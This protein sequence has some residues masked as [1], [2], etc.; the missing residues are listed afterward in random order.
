MR[1][2]KRCAVDIPDYDSNHNKALRQGYCSYECRKFAIRQT[3]G[4]DT[5]TKCAALI[6]HPPS[7]RTKAMRQGY[8]S[9]TCKSGLKPHKSEAVPKTLPKGPDFYS[10]RE[11][12]Q[13]RYQ[14]LKFHGACCQACG[15]SR[16]DGA[17][18]HVDHIKP[19]SKFPELALS[20]SNLQVLC[21]ECNLGKSNIDN[22]DWRHLV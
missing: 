21:G 4:G 22:T 1:A 3:R 10:S 12:L 9:N 20:L 11:W 16:V 6:P 7:G 14:V 8:C 5:C 2:C 13:L 19:R 17:V 18:I 15:K